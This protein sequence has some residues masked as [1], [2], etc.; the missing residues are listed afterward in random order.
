M[1][2][3]ISKSNVDRQAIPLD[4]K[5]RILDL[6]S[7]KFTPPETGIYDEPTR[8][9]KANVE[10][11]K[12]IEGFLDWLADVAAWKDAENDNYVAI[13]AL[14]QFLE[15]TDCDMPLDCEEVEACLQ[16]SP[17]IG[18]IN[19]QVTGGYSPENIEIPINE[20]KNY[21]DI[22]NEL[23]NPIDCGDADKNKLWGGISEFVD[24][25]HAINLDFLEQFTAI[26]S[27]AQ[28]V[29]TLISAIPVVGAIGFF[30]EVTELAAWVFDMLRINYAANVTT[31]GLY[32]LKCELFCLAVAND[33][34]FSIQDASNYFQSDSGIMTDFSSPI[35][36]LLGEM[37]SLIALSNMQWFSA[38]TYAQLALATLGETFVLPRSIKNYQN[39]FNAGAQDGSNGW[40][41]WCDECAD[42]YLTW[43]VILDFANDYEAIADEVVIRDAFNLL[44]TAGIDPGLAGMAQAYQA[45]LGVAAGSNVGARRRVNF[46]NNPFVTF[47]SVNVRS[48]NGTTQRWDIEPGTGHNMP[49]WTTTSTVFGWQ[50]DRAPALAGGA[51]LSGFNIVIDGVS[52]PPFSHTRYLRLQGTGALPQ[53]F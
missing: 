14:L 25:S 13:Q 37:P 12:I 4:E 21:P 23:N 20:G 39:S 5:Q 11:A 15:G 44:T 29:A 46:S 52:V 10:W 27:K 31:D 30:D 2:P 49:A 41:I 6:T 19:D 48:L 8:C 3:N 45:G 42:E 33:C 32:E 22:G 24:Y 35:L 40:Q 16:T 7:F 17:T 51:N 36:D 47:F 53:F 1:N 28:L 18:G 34:N 9:Y 38:I 50:T 43:T 26:A